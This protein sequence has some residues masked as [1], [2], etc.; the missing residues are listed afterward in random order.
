MK[1]VSCMKTINIATLKKET[2]AEPVIAKK[3]M[4]KG[5]MFQ[6][7]STKRTLNMNQLLQKHIFWSFFS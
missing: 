5:Q 1:I 4:L 2:P 3:L 6:G 7:S